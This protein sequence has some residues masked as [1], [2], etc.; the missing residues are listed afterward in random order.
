[1]QYTEE[2]SPWKETETNLNP[3]QLSQTIAKSQP[4]KPNKLAFNHNL[5]LDSS[6]P[7]LS[8]IKS[9]FTVF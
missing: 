7:L 2:I 8:Q 1:M 9:K 4:L 6:Q 5:P 3:L